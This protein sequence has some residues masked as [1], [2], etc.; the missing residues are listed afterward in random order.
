MT[1]LRSKMIRELKIRNY[2][3]DTQRAY[4]SS[5]IEL[6][7]F[8]KKSPD[9]LSNEDIKDYI[10]HLTE[11]RQLANSTLGQKSAGIRFFYHEVLGD[12]GKYIQ[13]PPRKTSKH[14]P[15]IL[16]VQ[17]LEKL[18]TVVTNLKHKLMLMTTYSAGLRVS[19]LVN[20]KPIHIESDRMQ[21][22]VEQGKG[23]KDRYTIL[24][25]RLLHELRDY[26]KVYRPKSWL[27]PR[28]GRDEKMSTKNPWRV[29]E[30][31]RQKA[32]IKRGNGIHTLRH[33]FGTH[34]LEAGTDVR[35]IQQLMGHRS[36]RTTAL[37]LQVSTKRLASV[38]SP[39]DLIE[40]PK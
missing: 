19:E 20:L 14:L 39:F 1:P 40:L 17:E 36:L 28:N 3:A 38:K 24:S 32:G 23:K 34:L 2:A 37:Y 15:Q 4:L 35:I 6:A 5:V 8:F 27:F 10:L 9:K 29:Y 25:E 31:N 22:R 26:W 33:C 11:D 16:S 21:I 7:A 18:F 12:K 30:K 13:I